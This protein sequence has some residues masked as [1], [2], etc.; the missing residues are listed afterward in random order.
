MS[1]SL[2]INWRKTMKVFVLIFTYTIDGELMPPRSVIV[3]ADE[4]IGFAVEQCVESIHCDGVELNELI[5]I[6]EVTI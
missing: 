2:E 6:V 3:P 1:A 5:K 4:P